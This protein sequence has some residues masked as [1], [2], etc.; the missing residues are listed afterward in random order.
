MAVTVWIVFAGQLDR[1]QQAGFLPDGELLVG[2]VSAAG[3]L[4]DAALTSVKVTPGDE[5]EWRR[6]DYLH[7][8][9]R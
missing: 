8:V 1:K 9:I 5:A 6:T 3:P 7:A 2:Q 4:C